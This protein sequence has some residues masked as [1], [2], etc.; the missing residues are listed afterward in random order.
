MAKKSKKQ[1]DNFQQLSFL[2]RLIDTNTSES[3][4]KEIVEEEDTDYEEEFGLDGSWESSDNTIEPPKRE[5]ITLKL[6][7]EAIIKQNPHDIVM[8]DFAEYV[9]PNL[10][11]VAIGVT[12][13]GGKWIEAKLAEV[14]KS[15]RAIGD[16]SLNTHL[17]NGLFP[18]N[19]I[20]KQVQK[21]DTTV[22]RVIKEKERR[23][24]TSGFILHDFEKFDYSRFPEMPQKYIDFQQDKSNKVRN[25]SIAEH[26]EIITVIIKYLNLDRLIDPD[27]TE[28]YLEY[29]DDILFIAYNTQSRYDTNWNLSEYSDLKP[30]LRGDKLNSLAYLSCLADRFASIIK[31]PQDAQI[32]SVNNLVGQLSN[33]Q[34]KLSYHSIAENRGVLT[35]VVNNALIDAHLNLNED[36]SRY[37][38][39]L[40]YL[41]TGVIYLTHRHAPNVNKDDTPEFVVNKIKS[42][43][44]EEL[45]KRQTGFNRDGKGIKYPDYYELFFD[46]IGLMEV[47]LDATLR[48]LHDKKDPVSTSR[49]ENLVSFQE[50]EVLPAH[51]DFTFTDDIRIDRLAEFGDALTRKIWGTKFEQLQKAIKDYE[52]KRKKNKDLPEIPLLELTPEKLVH[53]IAEYLG[54]SENIPAIQ[55]LQNINEK[56]KAKKLKGNTGGVP[57]EWYYLSAQYLKENGGIED[58][59]P[60]GEQ[61]IDYVA[62]LIKPVLENYQSCDISDNWSDVKAWVK[63]VVMLPQ[64]QTTENLSSDI[65]LQELNNYQLAKKSGRGRQQICSVSHSAYT[66]TKQ[67]E[68]AV[69]FMPQVY[70]NKQMLGG[71]N[72]TRNI[73]SI[74]GLEMMLRQILMSQTKAI[75]K[76]FEESKFR[77]LY[78]YPTYYCTPETNLFL[79]KAYDNIR[80]TRFDTGIRNH[81][82]SK[83]L[84]ANLSLENYQT[85]DVF[86][87]DDDNN[88]AS[89]KIDKTFKLSYPENQAP[90][91]YFMALPPEKKGKEKKVSDTESWIM[92]TWL[93]FAFPMILDVKVAVSESPIPPFVDASEFNETV[94]LDSPP[95]SIKSLVKSDR[96]RLDYILEGWQEGDKNYASPLNILTA[97]YAIHLDVNAKQTKTGYDANWSKLSELSRDLETTPLAVFS[98]VNKWVRNKKLETAGIK[99]IKL[100]A[101]DFYPCFD[102]HTTFNFEKEEFIMQ[103]ESPLNHPLELTKLYRQFYRAKSA[104]GKP[105]KANAILKPIDEAADVVLKVDKA[106]SKNPEALLHQVGARIFKLMERVHSSTAEGRWV[107]AKKD[108]ER[109]AILKF[110]DY[111]VNELFMGAFRG[112]KARLAGRQ[113]NIIR[114]TCEFLYRLEN[115][116]EYQEKKAQGLI[117]TDDNSE[118]E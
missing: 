103:P 98:Y 72:A 88:Q 1:N 108:E 79:Q 99:K 113:L 87:L 45:K 80:Q 8:A 31:H 9:L 53:Q 24:S 18:A 100:Y 115:D 118:E 70:T 93:S 109:E 74:A 66:V 95:I 111:F 48:I 43:C 42:L 96:F 77:Y 68:S 15:K 28:G 46:E 102:A 71:S 33:R 76:N 81:F 32:S 52:T 101:Y 35:N 37:Y 26:R 34:L 16:Q 116:K 114:D 51:Y 90:T 92:P 41:P 21:L 106:I 65:F 94:F 47:A 97:S 25:L 14:I 89:T 64:S 104:K 83:D 23:L 59:R 60:I 117:K 78:F 63:Q 55:S 36:E 54:L 62:Q 82:I 44:K 10:L 110:A 19:L 30:K 39:P 20:Q 61:I 29:L 105:I 22:R 13:K 17:L 57:Y 91:F 6:L 50:K 49:S 84:Q 67:R 58:I 69:L 86:N 11:K 2:D 27:N 12:A 3:L 38:L 85:V 107:I 4:S 75:G 5:L 73:S 112:D 40:L 56:L 7:Q